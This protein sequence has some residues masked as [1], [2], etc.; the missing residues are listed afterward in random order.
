MLVVRL[1]ELADRSF[2]I[3]HADVARFWRVALTE[4]QRRGGC[5]WCGVGLCAAQLQQ[6]TPV[7]RD[8]LALTLRMR[9]EEL[10]SH[11]GKWLAVQV[12][13]SGFE[14]L[15]GYTASQACLALE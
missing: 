8:R 6:A 4:L 10:A 11:F 2:Q 9:L 13:V 3:C 15:P 5:A 7:E 1:D 12:I 14:Q